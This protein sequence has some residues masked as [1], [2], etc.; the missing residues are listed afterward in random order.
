MTSE[1]SPLNEKKIQLESSLRKVLVRTARN[2]D[3][4]KII[5]TQRS[6]KWQCKNKLDGDHRG[7]VLDSLPLLVVVQES[8]FG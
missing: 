2:R 7:S 4:V 3:V 8:S 5:Q 1:K 6:S